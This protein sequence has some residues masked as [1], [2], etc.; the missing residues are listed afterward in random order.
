MILRSLSSAASRQGEAGRAN[1]SL[2]E[3]FNKMVVVHNDGVNQK[4]NRNV[5][6]GYEPIHLDNSNRSVSAP[7]SRTMFNR[8]A[9]SAHEFNMTPQDG[10][11]TRNVPPNYNGP[12]VK[13]GEVHLHA[14]MDG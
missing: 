2:L 14:W 7:F 6:I 3:T 1:A 11:N 9:R 8:S 12:R 13:P 10:R 5:W 4:G